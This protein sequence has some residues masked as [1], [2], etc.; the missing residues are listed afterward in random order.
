MVTST[1]CLARNTPDLLNILHTVREARASLRSIAE[2]M[3]DTTSQLAK[4]LIAVLRMAV[5]YERHRT[6]K[7]TAAGR[8]RPKLVQSSSANVL[9]LPLTS[10]NKH[11]SGL[12]AATRITPSR[13]YLASIRLL[14]RGCTEGTVKYL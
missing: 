10:R 11:Y 4:V 3:V 6:I 14:Y 9:P 5:S 13:F 2:L 12:Q 8:A 1:D 7:R